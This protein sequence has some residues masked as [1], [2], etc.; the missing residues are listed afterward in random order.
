MWEKY[1]S[2]ITFYSNLANIV[3]IA[4]K[5]INWYIKL[6][7]KVEKIKTEFCWTLKFSFNATLNSGNYFAIYSFI[8]GTRWQVSTLHD[9]D[10]M[11]ISKI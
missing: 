3:T 10:Y 1:L 4:F 6:L 8:S 11:G 7:I 2:K 9:Y 5:L